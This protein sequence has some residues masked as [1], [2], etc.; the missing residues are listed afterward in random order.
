M[1]AYLYSIPGAIAGNISRSDPTVEP[2]I[3]DATNPPTAFGQPVVIDGT[4]LN[5][6]RFMTGDL[7]P[8]V[9]GILVR[10]FPMQMGTYVSSHDF[11]PGIP[12]AGEVGDVLKRGYIGVAVKGSTAAVKNGLVYV[13]TVDG[14]VQAGAGANQVV[15]GGAYFTGAADSYGNAEIAFNL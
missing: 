1:S 15:V 4:S 14:S 12:Q 8:A 11:G 13:S 3:I 2:Q 6:R 9:Y 10:G 7:A 5:A